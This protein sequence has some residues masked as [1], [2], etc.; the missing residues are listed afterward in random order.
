MMD[1]LLWLYIISATLTYG[2]VFAWLQAR[3][4]NAK[5]MYGWHM[6]ISLVFASAA[7]LGT[8]SAIILTKNFR[9]G[10]KWW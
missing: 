2:G 5:R 4:S 6:V 10:F 3:S 9:S 7:P 1:I 8:F